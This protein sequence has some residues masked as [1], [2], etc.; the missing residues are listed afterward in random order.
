M[1]GSDGGN[2]FTH[3]A[4]RDHVFTFSYETYTD[5]VRRGMM[6]PPDRILQTLMASP[7]V[8]GLLV[9]NPYRSFSST[10]ASRLRRTNVEFPRSERHDLVQPVRMSRADATT[11][12]RL[13]AGYRRYDEVLRTAASKMGLHHPSVI[14]TNPLVA[15]FAPFA[16]AGSVTY[17]GRDDWLSSETRR[18]YW[19]AYRAAYRQIRDAE[20]GVVAVSEQ[21]IDRIAPRGPHAVVPNGVEPREWEGLVPPAPEWLAAIPRPRAIYV[22][23]IDNR[24][25]TE[26]IAA[27]AKARPDVSFVLLGPIPDPDYVSRVRSIP[28]IHVHPGVGRQELVAA[29]RNS[30]VSL[31]AHRRTAL[32]EAMSPLKVYEYLA[33]GLPVSAID[34]PPIRGI[35]ERVLIA[36]STADMAPTL[37]DALALGP[38][39]EI[40]RQEFIR[41]HSWTARH[42]VI[43][44]MTC[45]SALLQRGEDLRHPV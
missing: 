15:A 42:R 41:S 2:G 22:G 16:W 6:R 36:P 21:I 44:D 40:V 24:L 19:P 26:G 18:Q 29:L 25:D 13:V 37:D 4:P 30:Q 12:R 35:D 27:L 5:A 1:S 17:F 8:G 3:G 7:R 10:I 9:A 28:N 34:L 45:R 11:R 38:A 39:S 20:I 23:T 32:T 31:L 43:L 14:T 33:A